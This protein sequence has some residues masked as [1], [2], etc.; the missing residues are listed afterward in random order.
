MTKKITFPW[1]S[2]LILFTHSI[3]F[4]MSS[5]GDEFSQKLFSSLLDSREANNIIFSPY[6]IRQ[7]LGI[8]ASGARGLTQKQLGRFQETV[9]VNPPQKLMVANRLWVQIGYPLHEQ[10][11]NTSE[12]NFGIRPWMV[13]FTKAP[14]FL[15]DRVNGWV[16]EMTAGKIKSIIT[17]D[18]VDE[19]MKMMLTSALYFKGDWATPFDRERTEKDE[20]VSASG[21]SASVPFLQTTGAFKVSSS[22]EA[23]VLELPYV[24]GELVMLII[25][26]SSKHGLESTVKALRYEALDRWMGSFSPEILSVSLPAFNYEATYDLTQTL[27]SNG[28][29]APFSKEEADFSGMNGKKDLYLGRAFHKSYVSVSAAGTEGGAGSS[30]RMKEAAREPASATAT[31]KVNRP[32][33]FAVLPRNSRNLGNALLLGAVRNLEAK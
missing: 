12:K 9:K 32:F 28:I 10:Y 20:F 6:I 5:P 1:L 29:E 23:R 33:I 11:M 7:A 4:A 24:G 27:Q 13:D 18:S 3:A 19:T 14:D 16:E 2:L 15:K 8:A 25:L 21:K 26:P 22:T 17:E 31:F 30:I